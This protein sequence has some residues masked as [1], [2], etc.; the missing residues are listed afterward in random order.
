M[1]QLVVLDPDQVS[2]AAATLDLPG[3]ALVDLEIAVPEV[4]LEPAAL[5][6]VV[7]QRPQDL[8]GKSGVEG[9][10]LVALE[11]DR[12]QIEPLLAKLADDLPPPVAFCLAGHDA[13]PAHPQTATVAQ[14]RGESRDQAARAGLRP[15]FAALLL[16]SH[17]QAVRNNDQPLL[18]N[19]GHPPCK[20]QS[21][22]R[23]RRAPRRAAPA[24]GEPTSVA[25]WRPPGR[26][27][28]RP[29]GRRTHPRR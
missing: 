21:I 10:E 13:R 4:G 15:P 3:K 20:H 23:G 28:R 6:K 12:H 19:H 7:E 18:L 27:G 25:V 11:D 14:D 26:P 17:R 16:E 8:V 22:D 9:L 29:G 1:D 2:G 24:G 5:E